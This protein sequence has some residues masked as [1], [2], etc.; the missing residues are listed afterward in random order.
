MA[1]GVLP[2]LIFRQSSCSLRERLS[3][4]ILPISLFERLDGCRRTPSNL[5]NKTF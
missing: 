4:F 1:E 2:I 5:L 3:D